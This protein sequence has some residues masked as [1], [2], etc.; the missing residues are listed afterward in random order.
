MKLPDFYIN[1]EF[2]KLKI[3]KNK[4]GLKIGFTLSIKDATLEF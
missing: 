4:E 3:I 2:T 1:V